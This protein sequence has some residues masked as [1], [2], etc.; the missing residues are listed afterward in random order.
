[1]GRNKGLQ[2]TNEKPWKFN[3]EDIKIKWWERLLL[4]FKKPIMSK[5]NNNFIIVK[6][7]FGKVY[8]IAEGVTNDQREN[9][10][11]D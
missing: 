5:D 4:K 2:M 11:S 9:K 1:M 10:R 7:M 3:F 6:Y 8:I